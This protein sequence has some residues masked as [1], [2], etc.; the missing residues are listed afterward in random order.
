VACTFVQS[1]D[2]LQNGGPPST[3]GGVDQETSVLPDGGVAPVV[4]VPNQTKPGLLAQD[5][6]ALYWEAAGAIMTAPKAGGRA[7]QLG[8]VSDALMLAVDDDPAGAVY[9]AAGRDV[10]R[11]LKTGGDAGTVFAGD[12]ASALTVDTVAADQASLF[13]LQVDTMALEPSLLS[14]MGKDGG[15]PVVLD[16]DSG[17]AT[18]NIDSKVVLWFDP[19]DNNV[20][21]AFHELPK[22]AAP[23]TA[24]TALLLTKGDDTPATSDDIVL[25]DTSL[26][27][28][29]VEATTGTP[30]IVSRKREKTGT[31]I[32][33][34][35]GAATETFSSIAADATNLYVIE[36]S[37]S[38]ILR[39]PKQ[40][41]K[42]DKLLVGLQAPS[43]LVVDATSLYFTVE[44][45]GMQGAVMTLAK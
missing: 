33:L 25:D 39:V 17:P 5:S 21:G 37:T 32:V 19:N 28:L 11:L 27:W 26:Y 20:N 36:T 9:V 13:V 16:P 22:T 3:D 14:R 38:S 34:Y 42:A 43:S 29:T 2:Y 23:G 41:G 6:T 10:I 35:R 44:A 7:R 4:L 1:L 12:A 24:S 45:T 18:M 15:A 31:A 40:G 8:F 30:T